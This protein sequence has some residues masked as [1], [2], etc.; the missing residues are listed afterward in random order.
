MNIEKREKEVKEV[1]ASTFATYTKE[2]I[3][4]L[5][6]QDINN[7]ALQRIGTVRFKTNWKYETD[8]WGMGRLVVVTFQGAEVEVKSE[9]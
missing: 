3:A 1:V 6:E 2:E 9:E 4:T 7:K 5:I 8:E